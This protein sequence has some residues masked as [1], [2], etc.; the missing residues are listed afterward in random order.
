MSG[1]S[2]HGNE[3]TSQDPSKSTN[4]DLEKHPQGTWMSSS[5][6]SAERTEGHHEG[7]MDFTDALTL[8]PDEVFL[9][10]ME[11]NARQCSK[12]DNTKYEVY[13]EEG[14]MD[15]ENIAMH[16]AK[17][18]KY[19]VST[20]VT[21]ISAVIT[22]ISSC[23]SLVAEDVMSQFHISREVGVL[24]ITF[25]IFG[26]AVGPLIL[27]PFSELYGRRLTYILSM[28]FS[29]AFQCLVIWSPDIVGV[30]FGRFLSGFFGSSF[31]SVASGTIS[32]FFTKDE[33]GIPMTF[34][35]LAPFLGPSLG[36]VLSGAFNR[37]GYRWPFIV[38]MIASSVLLGLITLTVPESYKPVLLIRKAKR[39]RKETGD[40]RFYAPL[41]TVR[42]EANIFKLVL[43]SIRRPLSLL[44]RDYMIGVLS[45]YTGLVLA[46]I[47]LYFEVFPYI[48]PKLWNFTVMET[49][50]AY[51]GIL[52]GIILVCPSCL[53]FQRNYSRKVERNGGTSTPEMRFEALFYGAFF[54]PVGLMIFAW[55][56]FSHVH[57]I[58]SIIGSAIFG[59]G[60]FFV[61]VG[62]F[63]YTTDAYKRYTASAMACNTFVRCIMSGVFPLFGRQMYEGMGINWAGF[64][65]AMIAIGMIP[66]PFLFS[67]Y[68]PTLRAKSPYA[69]DD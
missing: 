64:L 33:I 20:L 8:N 60:V 57:W 46:I 9:S 68:G 26:M 30:F 17:P 15:P 29:V 43:N 41:E 25:Y 34:F 58:G 40:E 67:K 55:T 19:Y 45:F 4:M 24:G 62:V 6:V 16:I 28:G 37:D 59:A 42:S 51:F 47:Y 14:S 1:P 49:G 23:W 27:S 13:F 38:M 39:L 7:V 52:S 56:C 35:A 3:E 53:I 10:R 54:T 61:F 21:A 2:S 48:Y 12:E 44:V 63:A 5:S 65:L 66:V 69:W 31:L 32:D 36:P 18:R 11:K 50:L 22:M